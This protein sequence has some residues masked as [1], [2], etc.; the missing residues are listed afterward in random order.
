VIHDGRPM[1]YDPIQGQGHG[2]PKD[3]T[4]ADYKVYLLRQYVRN[5][6]TNGERHFFPDRVL[7]FVL[8]WCHM[9]FKSR[10]L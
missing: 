8:V 3:V 2:S 5:Q 1:P 10:V 4:M 9:T 6:K 7:I